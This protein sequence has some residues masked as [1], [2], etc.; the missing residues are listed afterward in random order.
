MS[1][2]FNIS[3]SDIHLI[4]SALSN[5]NKSNFSQDQ[6]NDIQEIVDTLHYTLDEFEPSTNHVHDLSY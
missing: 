5:T 1:Y 2:T 6:Q 3:K 4:I